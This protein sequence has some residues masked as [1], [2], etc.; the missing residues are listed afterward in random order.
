[1]FHVM[2]REDGHICDCLGSF[3]TQAAAKDFCQSMTSDGLPA[4]TELLILKQIDAYRIDR[5]LTAI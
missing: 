1:M 5:V 4:G 3:I 2:R